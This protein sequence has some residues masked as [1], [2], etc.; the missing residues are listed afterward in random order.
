MP[1]KN[2]QGNKALNIAALDAFAKAEASGE[3][4][5]RQVYLDIDHGRIEESIVEVLPLEGNIDDND[6]PHKY[7]K[8][9]VKYTKN[10]INPHADGKETV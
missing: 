9:I 5:E 2:N 8:V 1:L 6:N 10:V 7:G 3:K 4:I